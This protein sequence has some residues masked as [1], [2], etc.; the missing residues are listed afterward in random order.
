MWPQV[1]LT[2]KILWPKIGRLF[3]CCLGSLCEVKIPCI[4]L[5]NSTILDIVEEMVFFKNETIG[6]WGSNCSIFESPCCK[7]TSKTYSPLFHGIH[8]FIALTPKE[9]RPFLAHFLSLGRPLWMQYLFKKSQI[10]GEHVV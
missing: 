5:L 10:F 6:I 9:P 4:F 7:S 2:P 3:Y 1:I 8:K